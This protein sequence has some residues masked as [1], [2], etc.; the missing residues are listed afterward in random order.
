MILSF[1]LF[2]E[3]LESGEKKQTIRKYS[4]GQ[5]QRL[6]NCWKKRET[7]G[8]YNLYW[9][10]PRNGG[11]RIKDVVPSEK[12]FLITF[13]G[14]D[15]PPHIRTVTPLEQAYN[16]DLLLEFAKR[17][18]F[19]SSGEMWDWFESAYGKDMYQTKFIVIRW[20]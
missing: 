6:L 14:G 4:P 12:P 15:F 18:G 16:P 11:K 5:Y 20:E 10:N 7:D 1:S 9:H 19:V 17:D 13:H 3:K 8:R 2:K